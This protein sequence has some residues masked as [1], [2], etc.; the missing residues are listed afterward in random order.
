MNYDD[1]SNDAFNRL[2]QVKRKL[3]EYDDVYNVYVYGSANSGLQLQYSTSCDKFGPLFSLSKQYCSRLASGYVSLHQAEVKTL[4]DHLYSTAFEEGKAGYYHT[5]IEGERQL[6]I[7]KREVTEQKWLM[8]QITQTR[9]D[10]TYQIEVPGYRTFELRQC[11]KYVFMLSRARVVPLE[12]RI[13]THQ[14][15]PTMITCLI[16]RK[17]GSDITNDDFSGHFQDAINDRERLE[18]LYDHIMDLMQP[19]SKISLPPVDTLTELEDIAKIIYFEKTIGGSES[20]K[21]L[22]VAFLAGKYFSRNC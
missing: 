7:E 5:V 4:V 21:P 15:L 3:F 2:A 8:T 20:I 22:L 14:L 9:K 6:V 10:K 1:G 11:L 16:R 17:S 18:Q 13:I 12:D 19:T